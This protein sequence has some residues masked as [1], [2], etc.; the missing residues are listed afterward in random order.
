MPIYE[1]RCTE[2]GKTFDALQKFSDAPYTLCGQSS[3]ACERDGEAKGKGAVER[4]ISSPSFQF[5]G[6]GWY[7]TDY[8]KS[9]GSKSGSSS[10]SE[11]GSSKSETPKSESGK[12]ETKTDSAKPAAAKD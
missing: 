2:C 6:S 5:K 4:L 12:S 11:N 7:V 9:G 1:Y 3:V 8:G 10:S